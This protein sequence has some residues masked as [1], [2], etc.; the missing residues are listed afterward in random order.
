MIISVISW[1]VMGIGVAIL[2]VFYFPIRSKKSRG[3]ASLPRST[4]ILIMLALLAISTGL[5]ASAVGAYFVYDG[6]R[7]RYKLFYGDRNRAR[8]IV[9]PVITGILPLIFFILMLL[10]TL[11]SSY[12]ALRDFEDLFEKSPENNISADVENPFDARDAQFAAAKLA[13]S[14]EQKVQ[15][16]AQRGFSNRDTAIAALRASNF[17]LQEAE[18]RLINSQPNNHS[19]PTVTR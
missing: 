16:L 7:A 18:L 17:D 19:D 4:L 14:Q 12:K 5:A 11:L 8:E 3:Y 2:L 15:H 6:T 9:V 1:V 13:P 10:S